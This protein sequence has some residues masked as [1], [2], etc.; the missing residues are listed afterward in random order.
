MIAQFLPYQRTGMFSTLVLDYLNQSPNVQPFYAHSV[1]MEGLDAAIQERKK[2]PTNRNLLTAAFTEAY[3]QNSSAKQLENIKLLQSP[4]CFTVCTAHQPN[5]FT[6][7][8][9]FIYKILHTIKLAKDLASA[10]PQYTFVPI[11]YMGSEDNDLEELGQVKVDGVKMVWKTKQTGAVGRMQV[12]KALLQI[13]SQIEQQLCILP[14]GAALNTILRDSYREGSTIGESTFRLVNH[15]FAEYG[16]LVL[17]ADLASLKTTML[18]VFKDDLVT[19]TPHQLVSNTISSLGEKYKVQVNPRE[20]NLFYLK[21][22]NRERIIFQNNHFT[23]ESNLFHFSEVEILA[24]LEAFPER[25]SP[26][27]VLRGLYQETILPNIAFIGGGAE[28]AYWLELKS[29]FTHYK[30]PFPVLLLRNS[31]LIANK[32]QIDQW[33]ALGLTIENLFQSEFEIMNQLVRKHS[34]L[35]ID[36]IPELATVESA[37]RAMQAKAAAIDATLQTHIEAL[38]TQ[39]NKKLNGVEKKMMRA[40]KRKFEEQKLRIQKLKG[41]LFPNNSLQERQ[42]NFMYFYA[43]YGKNFLNGIYLQSPSLLQEFG[44]LIQD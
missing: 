11:F 10:F 14:Q 6:G 17:N 4:D 1:S 19:N 7:Y 32:E 41:Q 31:F 16:L 29:L 13:I 21:D 8:L 33:L 5:I 20:I 40:E 36:I 24:E 3:N 28:I 25:F 43:K 15:L 27:V 38:L 37:F 34:N 2:F 44:V 39:L 30:V 12:D 9:Y 42:D 26:N 23:T 18:T 22:E 35:S